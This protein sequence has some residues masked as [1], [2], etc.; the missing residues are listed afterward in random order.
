MALRLEDFKKTTRKSADTGRV[1]ASVYPHQM[2]DKKA[3]T[4]LE[5]AIR[6]FDSLAGKRRGEL[7][8]GVMADFFGDPRIARGVVACLGQFYKYRTPA[9]AEVVGDAAARRLL[10]AGLGSPMRLRAHTYAHVN[11]AHH[12]FL[13][14]AGRAGCYAELGTPLG[15]S[16]HEWDTLLHLDAEENQVL[17]RTGPVPTAD[18]LAALYNFHS[19]DTPLRRAT[20]IVLAGLHLTSAEAADVRALARHLGVKAV[21]GEAGQTVTLT[22]LEMSSLLP[23]RPGRL[24]RCLLH[25]LQAFG[26]KSLTG[27]ADALLGTRTF[28]LTLNADTFKTLGMTNSPRPD[29]GEGPGVRAGRAP[30]RRRSEAAAALHKDLLRQRAQGEADGWRIARLPDPVVT[31]QGVLLPD[32]RLTRGDR[33]VSV[34]LG[35][36]VLGDWGEAVVCVPVGRKAVRATEVYARAGG[37][38]T[39]LFTLPERAAPDVPRDVR[40]LCDRAA[41]LGMVDAA[42]A[43]RALHLLDESPLIEWVRR[44]ADPRVRY[45]PG[46]GLCS[47]EL[48]A[49]ISSLQPS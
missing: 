44:A 11:Q 2:K 40:A 22:D 42:G 33:K 29:L 5:V 16:A 38:T 30:F 7:D 12:G 10:E 19:L 46:I 21:V 18:D 37:L 4:R 17:T 24:G 9:F 39:N 35:E 14:E 41:T 49:A 23:R 45:L 3:R 1:P 6:T 28:R 8:A 25:L 26:N 48:V 32:F 47:Q 27:H 15:L 34:V 31:A 43:L 36:E 13:A 20:R